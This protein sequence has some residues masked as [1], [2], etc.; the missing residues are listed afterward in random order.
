MRQKRILLAD[1]HEVVRSGLRS[2][3]QTHEGW[4]VV[5]EADNGKDA[6][7]LIVEKTPDVAIIDYSLPL[8]NGV[9]VTRSVKAR[10]LDT[11]ILIFTMHDDDA[12]I[13]E[14]FRAGARAFLLKSEAKPHLTAAVEAL[15]AHKPYFTGVVSEKMLASYLSTN[16]EPTV[17]LSPR[18]RVVI[19]LISEGYTNK[20]MSKV[21]NLSVKTIETHRASAMHKLSVKSTAGLV[22]YAI[23]NMLI[24]P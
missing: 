4:E 14:S 24:E 2:L 20:E 8:I 21:L 18:E 11:E 9:E 23:K 3:L 7:A 10:Q 13:R 19:Q 22:R 6:I 17:S 12:L 1:D 5:A 15:L 16:T